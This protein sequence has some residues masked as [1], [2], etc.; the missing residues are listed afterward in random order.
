MKAS[1]RASRYFLNIRL[2]SLE[3]WNSVSLHPEVPSLREDGRLT[4]RADHTRDHRVQ[5]CHRARVV[6]IQNAMHLF[7]IPVVETLVALVLPDLVFWNFSTMAM[8]DRVENMKGTIPRGMGSVCKGGG[9]ETN[10]WRCMD[11]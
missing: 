8:L 3:M 6:L 9:I 5:I 1:G 11:T 7:N 2:Q 4:D 10:T